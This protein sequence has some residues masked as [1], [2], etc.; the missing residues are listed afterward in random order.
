MLHRDPQPLVDQYKGKVVFAQDGCGDMKKSVYT[1]KIKIKEPRARPSRMRR[2]GSVTKFS[3]D[4]DE[5]KQCFIE[6]AVT[7]TGNQICTC[8]LE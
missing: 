7:G 6:A 3:R 5:A 2:R 1:V 4:I 8:G